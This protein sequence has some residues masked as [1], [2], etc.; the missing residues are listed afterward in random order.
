MDL[1][2]SS[3]YKFPG[4]YFNFSHR[5][6]YIWNMLGM[7]MEPRACVASRKLSQA[8][9]TEQSVVKYLAPADTLYLYLG[10]CS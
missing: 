7:S 4:K 8:I 5:C 3:I 6:F 9:W 10:I 2:T 1:R